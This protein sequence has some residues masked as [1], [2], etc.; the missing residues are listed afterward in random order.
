[1]KAVE[2]M[3]VEMRPNSVMQLKLCSQQLKQLP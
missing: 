2:D 3:T 1:M